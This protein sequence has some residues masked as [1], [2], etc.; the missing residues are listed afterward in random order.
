MDEDDSSSIGA[1]GFDATR[2]DFGG[3][4]LPYLRPDAP[5]PRSA[6]CRQGGGRGR[7]GGGLEGEPD[8]DDE[9]VVKRLY[10]PCL[11]SHTSKTKRRTVKG[12]RGVS[13]SDREAN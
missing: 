11:G 6:P 12:P 2:K 1:I 5:S 13:P 3:L 10:A 4:S 8:R 7:G 9:D